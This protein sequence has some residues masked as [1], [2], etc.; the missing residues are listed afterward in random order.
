MRLNLRQIEAF[1]AVF[2]TSSMTAAADLMG[3]T[4]PAVSRLI[5][6]LEAEIDL[7][8]FD[9]TGGRLLATEN[10]VSLI[11]EVERS[12]YGLDR[13]AK[14][15]AE[16]HH[17]PTGSLRL[18]AAV[19]PSFYWLPE[20]ITKFRE[21]QP[22]VGL[23]LNV[24]PSSEILDAVSMQQY[25]MGLA[26]VSSDAP[27]VEIEKLPP[28][29]FVC[30]LPN[31]HR[32]S[33]KRRITAK[34]FTNE[35]VVMISPDSHQ[36]QRIMK[37]FSST[38]AKLDIVVEASNSGPICAMVAH[39]AGISILDPITA[40]AFRN[41]GVTLRPF[42]PTV[43]YDL[44]LIYPANRPRSS[45]TRAFADLLDRSLQTFNVQR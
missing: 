33:R 36:Q 41:Q 10:A 26:D 30:A 16:L 12:F 13:I 5:R 38:Y 2:Q 32:L 9:R 25:D 1:R 44:K 8:L 27:G 15:A 20:I 45:Q 29:E 35:P 22:G 37:A 23:S 3:V 4:Q 14:A 34:D 18:A 21:S 19:G 39:G 7:P 43:S 28:L 42:A 40:R 24:L 11:R 17:R 6:D 31:G